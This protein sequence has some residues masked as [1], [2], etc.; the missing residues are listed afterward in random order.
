MTA[1]THV[2]FGALSYFVV[3][4]IVQWQPSTAAVATA[5]LGS[6]L[7]DIDLP[8]S[9]V[10]RPLFPIAKALNEQ[11]G[12]R[13]LTHSFVGIFLLLLI[14]SPL[15]FVDALV[16]WA[17]LIGYVS[18]LLID[19]V[20]KAGIELLYPSRLRAWFLNDERYRITV[21]S[22]EEFILLVVLLV[23]TVAFFPVTIRGFTGTLHYLLGDTES[24]VTDF[25]RHMPTHSV[26]ATVA[27]IDTIS[28]EEV[29]GDF[30]VL[31]ANPNNALIIKHDGRLREV[32]PSGHL[33]PERVRIRQGVPHKIVE[34]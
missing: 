22:R 3:A 33:R 5:A 1:P 17:L 12:H 25:Y 10:G 15:F 7:P 28:Q 19:T 18:P 32:G 14:L 11:I 21:G 20:N 30:S 16:L 8:T 27:A 2:T 9:A 23:F 34:Q 24:A 4:A 26:I 29:R 6:L 31:G 13:T